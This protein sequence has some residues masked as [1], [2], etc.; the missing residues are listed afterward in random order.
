MS[1]AARRPLPDVEDDINLD[2]GVG[3]TAS[4]TASEPPPET[5]GAQET[6][7]AVSG[8][9]REPESRAGD[10]WMYDEEP[11]RTPEPPKRD[12]ADTSRAGGRGRSRRTAAAPA[13]VQLSKSQRDD[14]RWR[15]RSLSGKL[16]ADE[17]A[18][19]ETADRWDR[20][21]A[22]ARKEGVPDTM[23]LVALM[24]A[25]VEDPQRYL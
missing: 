19:N 5:G 24:D 12:K 23:M 14:W 10:D 11:P 18:L 16:H 6:Q 22:E 2:R 7:E 21:V 8:R 9:E 25:G 17:A 4:R 1:A 20:L 13:A 3:P 15:L